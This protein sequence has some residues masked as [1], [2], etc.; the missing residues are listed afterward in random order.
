MTGIPLEINEIQCHH[1]KPKR[2][3]GTGEYKNL[4]I[5]HK[6]VHRLIH[7]K[8]GETIDAYKRL[9]QPDENQL[10]KNSSI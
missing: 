7:A 3:G 10:T 8:N 1:K 5:I 9:L 6:D 4:V 2:D